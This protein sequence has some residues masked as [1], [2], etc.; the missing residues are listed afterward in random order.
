MND[1]L[2]ELKALDA[3]CQKNVKRAFNY[4][5]VGCVFFIASTFLFL[6]ML[7]TK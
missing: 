7:L 2:E 1:L 4:L 3:E 6:Q 5:I